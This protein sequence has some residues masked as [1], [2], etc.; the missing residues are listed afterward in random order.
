MRALDELRRGA[1]DLSTGEPVSAAAS[2]GA[3]AYACTGCKN[4]QT[5]CLLDNPVA[6]TLRA[7]RSDVLSNGLAPDAVVRFVAGFDDRLA[8]LAER[9]RGWDVGTG[10]TAFVP[11]CTSVALEPE[12]VGDVAR[13]VSVLSGGSTLVADDCCGTPLL[14]AGDAQGFIA[15]ARHFA[16]RLADFDRV[17]TSDAGCAYALR[18]LYPRYGITVPPVEHLGETAARNAAM[19]QPVDDPRAVIYHDVCK[20]G[21]GLGVYDPPRAVLTALRGVAPMEM[22]THHDAA[23]CSGGGGL[24]PVALP[25]TA[26]AVGAE[27]ASEVRVGDPTAVVVTGCA[28]SRRSLRAH[29]VTVEDLAV[30]IARGVSGSPKGR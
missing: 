19:L 16:Q 28:V 23:R 21:R 12:S 6:D 8:R 2:R 4:C 15:Q 11:G 9:A 30:W 10:R 5:M 17:V 1:G 3:A 7:V 18:V 24:L 27:L 26:A 29:G 13:A 25:V 22:P 14:E 20:L